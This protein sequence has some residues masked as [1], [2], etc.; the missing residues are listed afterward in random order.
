MR[1]NCFTFQRYL[2]ALC[3][4]CNH[5]C[6]TMGKD[7]FLGHGLVFVSGFFAMSGFLNFNSYQ[8]TP[9]PRLFAKKRFKR[10][11]P[12][13][14]LTVVLCFLLGACLT[15]MPLKD[16]FTQTDT[17]RYLFFNLCFLN[18]Q[19]PTLPGVFEANAMPYVNSSL[20]TMKVEVLF[21]ITVPLVHW[22]IG[23][24]GK[25]KVLLT[26]IIGS[27]TYYY[28]TYI[29]YQL[30][31]NHIFYT[32]NHQLPG[33]LSFFYIPVLMLYH[34]DWVRQH[35]KPLL[36]G[37]AAMMLLYFIDSH[38][39]FLLPL[40]LPVLVITSAYECTWLL[41]TARWK[42]FS[43]EFYLFRF[44]VLQALTCL[45][46]AS[47]VGQTALISLPLIFAVAIPLHYLSKAISDQIK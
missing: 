6:A 43:Y 17:W 16:F 35:G 40:C 31:G 44:P 27:L 19:Q 9:S 33:E 4:F 30:T 23:K 18:Y 7:L 36:W 45:G 2:F 24:W 25:K 29:A 13:Y 32:L 8:T 20:W 47:S 28:A 22:F 42:D 10:I 46:L 11:Y 3:I 15:T 37:S 21:Y 12:A 5:V 38:F 14:G 1:N 39:S 34:F 26:I 41:P